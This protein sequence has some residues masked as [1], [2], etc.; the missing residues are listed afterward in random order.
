M[1][2][3]LS[4]FT[5][6]TPHEGIPSAP[7]LSIGKNMIDKDR[8]SNNEV[9]SETEKQVVLKHLKK[10]SPKTGKITLKRKTSKK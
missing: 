10:N 1:Q 3:N 5:F 8:R 7:A 2:Q 9:P 4:K 6:A